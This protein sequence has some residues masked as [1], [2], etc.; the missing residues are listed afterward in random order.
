MKTKKS[1]TKKNPHDFEGYPKHL[2]KHIDIPETVF[3][4]KERSSDVTLRIR[5][6]GN[7]K[8]HTKTIDKVLSELRLCGIDFEVV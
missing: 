4:E 5:S 8:Q 2:S 6:F 1:P 7:A 3:T